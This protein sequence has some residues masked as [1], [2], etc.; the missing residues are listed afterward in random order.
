MLIE[1]FWYLHPMTKSNS[2][3]IFPID[4]Y[5]YIFLQ[6]LFLFPQFQ[7]TACQTKRDF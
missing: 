3:E 1:K 4:L 7:G 6:N 2:T 5:I